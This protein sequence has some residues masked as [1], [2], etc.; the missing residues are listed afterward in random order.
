MK[1]TLSFLT[2][3]IMIPPARAV[4]VFFTIER[5]C[6]P[7]RRADGLSMMGCSSETGDC[8]ISS[9]GNRQS[10]A[11]RFVGVASSMTAGADRPDTC[12]LP[13][14]KAATKTHLKQTAEWLAQLVGEVVLGIDRQVVLKHVDRVLAA[15]VCC[16]SLGSLANREGAR[17]F[18]ASVW[19]C[20][21][22]NAIPERK[23][24]LGSIKA[25]TPLL[26][27]YIRQHLN[28]WTTRHKVVR[29]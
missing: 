17:A 26:S 4:G 2:A 3:N 23:A 19:N 12:V 29:G 27:Y 24:T 6:S 20:W 5:V 25:P 13:F 10:H 1:L 21:R 16:S 11:S 22:M 7:W 18:R 9:G 15:L 28:A 14:H 8:E